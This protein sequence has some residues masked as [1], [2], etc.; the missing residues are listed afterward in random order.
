MTKVRGVIAGWL[1]GRP[2]GRALVFPWSCA[3]C[4]MEGQ[5]G[6]FCG[7]PRGSHGEGHEGGGLSTLCVAGRPVRGLPSG[8]CRVP[9][10]DAGL[11]RGDRNGA[12][13]GDPERTLP[14][15]QAR[16]ECLAGPLPERTLG[17]VR[18]E[19]IGKLPS[20]TWIV[21][22]P[23]HWW[24]HWRRGYNQ[25][26][27]LARGLVRRLDRPVRRSIRRVVATDK[28]ADNSRT[29]RALAM[30]GAFRARRN[31]GLKGR[32]IILV[33]DVLTT[34]A[35]CAPRPAPERRRRQASRRRRHSADR[36]EHIVRVIP[37][38]R[39]VVPTVTMRLT[40]GSSLRH[41][42]RR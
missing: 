21:P 41:W 13:R 3:V 25:A 39:A 30:R 1:G 42:A 32:T 27:A 4:G 23:L 22:V 36:Q 35:T 7:L 40:W 11:R 20:D 2:R 16:A 34:G 24:R 37:G 28:L 9:G 8:L 18:G 29:E 6:A 12:L 5:G 33:D 17:R 19:A 26:E 38:S 31:S 15:T 14:A 10:P